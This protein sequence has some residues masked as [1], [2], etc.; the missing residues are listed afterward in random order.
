[1]PSSVRALAAGLVLIAAPAASHDFWLEVSTFTPVAGDPVTVHLRV[2]EQFSG[3]P[4]G[5]PEALD[6][7]EVAAG[8]VRRSIPGVPGADPAGVFAAPAGNAL[9][10]GYVSRPSYIELE[11]AAFEA[12]L[13]E[14]GLEEVID[15][16][17]R[18]GE[19]A[20][21]GRELFARSAKALL[22]AGEPPVLDLPLELLPGASPAALVVG[23]S[24]ALELRFRGRPVGDV[25]VIA[26][27]R[28]APASA[29]RARTDAS[30][31][32]EF[33]VDR[34]GMW[35]VKA[36]HMTATDAASDADW[37]S[38]WSSLT[39]SIAGG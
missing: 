10:V 26:M 19:S 20:L 6:R 38:W 4:V 17:A 16:R 18:R 2:G 34:P 11:A 23:D 15:L 35:L 7:F 32:V 31:R 24:L 28:D 33:E 36:V 3:S 1:M 21:P 27:P 37:M 9:G 8:P 12:Y 30:G 22:G 5:R 25:L 29:Q 39:F 13:L 14:E